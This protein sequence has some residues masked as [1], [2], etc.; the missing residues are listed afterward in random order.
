MHVLN[1]WAAGIIFGSLLGGCLLVLVICL[2]AS[3]LPY[4]RTRKLD[5]MMVLQS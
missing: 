1:S 2:T 5:P 3:L 4:L